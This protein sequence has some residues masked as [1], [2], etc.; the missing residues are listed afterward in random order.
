MMVSVCITTYNH[1]QFIAQ[2]LDGVLSQQ[3]NFDYEIL[4]GE[5]Q[6]SDRTREIAKEYAARHPERIRLFLH[7][8]PH[9][10]QRNG[11]AKNFVH[12]IKN[13]RGKY[14]ALLDGD[15]YWTSPQKLQKQVDLL[16]AHPECSGCFHN[17]LMDHEGAPEKNR[18]FHMAPLAKRYFGLKISSDP[19]IPIFSTI[20]RASM[21]GEFPDWYSEMP[22]GDWPLTY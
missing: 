2:A 20:F 6:S 7:D 14:I 3:T 1:E 8:Y 12:N 5:D 16:E 21:F 18:L 9:D 4:L 22:M 19:F 11:G 10:Y 17:V 13:A 15:D